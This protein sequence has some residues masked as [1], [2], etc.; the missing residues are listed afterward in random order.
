[1]NGRDI[2]STTKKCF[3]ELYDERCPG[4]IPSLSY[5][6]AVAPWYHN[7]EKCSFCQSYFNSL[8]G[9]LSVW[10]NYFPLAYSSQKEDY[11]RV[12][13]RLKRTGPLSCFCSLSLL[14]PPMTSRDW[15]PRPVIPIWLIFVQCF[16][17]SFFWGLSKCGNPWKCDRAFCQ[18]VRLS[19]YIESVSALLSQNRKCYTA[20]RTVATRHACCSSPIFLSLGPRLSLETFFSVLC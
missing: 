3:Q 10:L 11:F 1:M 8:K 15:D 2:L 16:V 5:D 18:L 7:C 14:S 13:K 12:G 20:R 6:R 4:N 17:F 19:P 9:P